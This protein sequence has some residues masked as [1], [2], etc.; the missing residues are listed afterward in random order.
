MLCP[1]W[2]WRLPLSNYWADRTIRV[3]YPLLVVVVVGR[4]LKWNSDVHRRPPQYGESRCGRVTPHH[5]V[6]LSKYDGKAVRQLAGEQRVAPD[7]RVV[8]GDGVSPTQSEVASDDHMMAGRIPCCERRQRGQGREIVVGQCGVDI[9]VP[10]AD[11]E[12]V[13]QHGE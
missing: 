4:G 7:H 10:G 6:I 9:Q 2:T 3:E 1:F 5:R 11:R 12:N 13:G 8:E